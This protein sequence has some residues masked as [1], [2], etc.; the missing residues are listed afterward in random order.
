MEAGHVDG[1]VFLVFCWER[2][3]PL[4]YGC[5]ASRS[6]HEHGHLLSPRTACSDDE[7]DAER[8]GHHGLKTDYDL[9]GVCRPY[10]LDKQTGISYTLYG[11]D[12]RQA[13]QKLP[14]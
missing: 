6:L 1:K 13:A 2:L 11:D 3:F 14:S 8:L 10:Y 4:S 9:Q 12:R 5:L 7:W